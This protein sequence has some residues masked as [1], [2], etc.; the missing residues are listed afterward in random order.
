[1]K[2]YR[3]FV[4]LLMCLA[5]TAGC[6]DITLPNAKE[7]LKDPLGEGSLKIGMTKDAVISVYGGPDLERQVYS[8]EWGGSR[9]EWLYKS[10]YSAFPVNAG[11]FSE[12]LYLYFDGENL[13]NVSKTP[14]GKG[15]QKGNGNDEDI[16]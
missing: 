5:V 3:L 11:Y 12:D 2:I 8:D 9:E 1:M 16:K 10:R 6:A 7:M 13:T 4:L 15:V 14:L